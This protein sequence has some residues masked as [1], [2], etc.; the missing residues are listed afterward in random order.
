MRTNLFAYTATKPS[1]PEY[2]SL[3]RERSGD[4]VLQVRGEANEGQCG[5]TVAVALPRA[6][7]LQLYEALRDELTP[8]M[9]KARGISI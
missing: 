9:M 2:V 7:L 3:N 4:I 1:Y 5:D 8:P 6:A